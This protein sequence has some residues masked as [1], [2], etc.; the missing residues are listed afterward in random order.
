MT[1]GQATTKLH[2]DRIFT[3]QHHT[4]WFTLAC[5]SATLLGQRT[6]CCQTPL[7]DTVTN[8]LGKIRCNGFCFL[9]NFP[10]AAEAG[11]DDEKRCGSARGIS[12]R[13][14]AGV[15]RAGASQAD[16]TSAAS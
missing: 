9:G 13:R 12:R 14:A 3:D 5:R 11:K 10:A 4:W 16:S 15:S 1:G 6:L 2:L 8:F 7:H